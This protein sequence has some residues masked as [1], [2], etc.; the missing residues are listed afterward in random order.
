[1][2]IDRSFVA[3]MRSSKESRA[4]VE[5]TLSMARSFG[6]SVVAE[7]IEDELTAEA[8]RQMGCDIGQG[9]LFS[10][11]MPIENLIEMMETRHKAA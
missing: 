6:K 4:I 5:A 7:G 11:A 10:P 1:M 3:T 8:L 2:K 9:F